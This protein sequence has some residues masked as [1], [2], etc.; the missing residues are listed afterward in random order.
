MKGMQGSQRL[1]EISNYALK[2]IGLKCHKTALTTRN[3]T[4]LYNML[5]LH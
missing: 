5:I 3:L 1:D 2:N 4:C